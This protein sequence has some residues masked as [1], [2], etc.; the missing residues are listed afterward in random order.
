MVQPLLEE[1]SM[2]A[3]LLSNGKDPFDDID[4]YASHVNP[5]WSTQTAYE[6]A[7]PLK[8]RVIELHEMGSN[9]S[10]VH[11]SGLEE[12]LGEYT[13]GILR[14]ELIA[15]EKGECFLRIAVN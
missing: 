11:S 3:V 10:I 5:Y 9:E 15:V 6:K 1:D 7:L 12:R 13:D 14:A 8:N 2:A 4:Q